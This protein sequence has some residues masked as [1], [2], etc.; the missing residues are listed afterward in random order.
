VSETLITPSLLLL[1][2]IVSATAANSIIFF[3]G[4]ET[5]T[6][7]SE[8]IIIASASF[9]AFLGV[10][11]AYRQILHNRSHS[12]I[13]ISLAI[14]LVLWLCADIIWASYE[15]VFHVA[16][17]IPSLSDIL[18][19]AG[20]P[21]F[22]YNLIATYI[23]FYNRVDKRVLLASIIGNVIFIAYLIWLTIGIS[24]FSS[25]GGVSMFAVLIAYPLMNALLTI[26][27]LP[28][29]LGLWKER[30]WSIPWTFKSLSLFCIVI[31][32]SW[33]AFII[34]SG[35]YE[36]V[37]LSSMFF[38]AEYLIL[39]GGL[40]W[41]N[42]FL[43]IYKDPGTAPSSNTNQDH[44][45]I[46]NG[47]GNSRKTP[48]RIRYLHVLVAVILV[49]GILSYG[50]ITSGATASTRYFGPVES[51]NTILIGAL[52]PI[53]GTLS[54]FG[55]SSEASLR[56][57]VEDVN[58]QLA[59]S[60]SSSR[61]GL[62]IEDTKTDPNVAREKLMDLA[63]KGIRIVI[64]PAT[65]ANV[66]A[67]KDYADENGI[68]IVSSS[69]TAPS[70]SIPNDNVFRF[71]PDDTHQA[72]VLAKKMW[73]EGTR[74]VIP[75]WRT[76]VFGNN[77]QSLLKE[78][79]EK[80][81][82]KVVDGVGY[83]PPVGN[84]AASLHRINFIVWEQELKS[85]T[86]KVN[87]AVRQYG[88]DK[89]GVYI[90][91]FDEI[92]PIMIQANRHQELQSVSWYGTDGSV[93][94]EGLIKNIEA[95]EFAVKTNFLSPIYGVE[96][97]DSFKKLEERIVEEIH[98]VPRSYAQ[99]TYDEFWVAALTLTLNNYTGTQQD[100]F[101]SLRQTFVNTANLYTGVTGRTELNDAG[102]RKNGSYD[103]WAIRP[104]SQDVNN[105]G[106]FEWTN[107]AA[108]PIGIDN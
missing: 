100:D 108:N 3:A 4:T 14:G 37:W 60:G 83:D 21:F 76:D 45:K 29:L 19:L 98:R 31:T 35:L 62:V 50:F 87:D 65:S 36:Q 41:F 13:Y 70:L 79:F 47:L 73:D 90:I 61:V 101:G 30:P 102:D 20:Y 28:I 16:A 56:L 97:S 81:G 64:G 51:T 55:E 39:A 95:A 89:V 25:Q 24:D 1:G 43:A 103:F 5:R 58:N 99:V 69:S 6:V 40:L 8:L 86:Q 7:Y 46:T 107:V 75:I 57:A 84:F 80:L 27:A 68:L 63:S 17:P 48:N 88:A 44:L 38:G 72:E 15:L 105:K 74:V 23:L 91:A 96:R 93:Q 49:G 22:A 67:V 2:L 32:D 11:L 42:K 9:A 59:K 53:T 66:A 54:S 34:L 82:G 92:V 94:N 10:V 85:L 71:V 104:L 26:P 52:L 106:S 78:K 77:L 12:K 18:W 33:F